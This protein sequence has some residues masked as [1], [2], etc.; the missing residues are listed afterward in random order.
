MSVFGNIMSRIFGHAQAAEA[1][2]LAPQSSATSAQAPKA[3]S[4][5][6][7]PTSGEK[8]QVDVAA[9]LIER[10]SKKPEKLDWK[11]SIVDLMKL[12]DLDSGLAAR[13]ELASELQYSGNNGNTAAMNVL[14]HKQL[15]KKRAE[16]GATFRMISKR[17]G[18]RDAGVQSL[19]GPSKR[20]P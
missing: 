5:A 14:L 1:A 8:P 16:N 15:M 9:V 17:D 3:P 12:L 20:R 11:H 19:V 2:P 13:K 4:P 6:S 7:S 10:A 18:T